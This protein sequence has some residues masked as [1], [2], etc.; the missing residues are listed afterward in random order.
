MTKAQNEAESLANFVKAV[1]P[2]RSTRLMKREKVVTSRSN[3]KWVSGS[4]AAVCSHDAHPG[5]GCPSGRKAFADYLVPASGDVAVDDGD[6]GDG[7]EAN[8][9]DD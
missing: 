1:Y 7:D 2:P 4:T 9:G 8:D 3:L 5:A 6:D